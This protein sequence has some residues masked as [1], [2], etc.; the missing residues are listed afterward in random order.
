MA[1]YLQMEKSGKAWKFKIQSCNCECI[2]WY[3]SVGQRRTGK[4]ILGIFR[5]LWILVVD[6]LFIEDLQK[7][8]VIVVDP[9]GSD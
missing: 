5:T 7:T 3:S 2:F 1:E 9:K 4:E 8:P 6:N